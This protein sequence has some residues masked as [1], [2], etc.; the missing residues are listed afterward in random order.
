MS[1]KRAGWLARWWYGARVACSGIIYEEA[2]G[3]TITRVTRY[4]W[5]VVE[6]GQSQDM[7]P[8]SS[9]SPE[10]I[11]RVVEHTTRYGTGETHEETIHL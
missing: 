2:D 7:L 9:C 1:K 6:D 4:G 3:K 5:V 10:F 8:L 11:N